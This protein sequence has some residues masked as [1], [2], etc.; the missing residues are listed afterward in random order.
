M[1][2]PDIYWPTSDSMAP[3]P[4]AMDFVEHM[5]KPFTWTV[6]AMWAGE[7]IGYVQLLQ[8]TSIMAELTTAFHP[9]ARGRI[10][11]T[12]VEHTIGRAFAERG[13]LKLMAV[14]PSDNRRAIVSAYV[15]H[16]K[17]EGRLTGAI[18][19]DGGVR[20]LLIFGLSR[21]PAPGVQ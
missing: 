15:L 19:R 1:R 11:K 2:R 4:E 9:Q 12:F 5:L 18:I 20:D 17:L 14:I 6:A 16:F 21:G 10:A 7:I 3:P 8:R 13:L